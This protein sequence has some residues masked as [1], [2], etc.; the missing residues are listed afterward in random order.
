MILIWCT[1]KKCIENAVVS[2]T[3]LGF[4]AV[5]TSMVISRRDQFPNIDLSRDQC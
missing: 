3:W 1:I 2:R 5:S 4:N